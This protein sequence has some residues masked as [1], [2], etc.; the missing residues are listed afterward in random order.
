MIW[1]DAST[2]EVLMMTAGK[3]SKKTYQQITKPIVIDDL[4]GLVKSITLDPAAP[5]SPKSTW[6]E[7][8]RLMAISDLEGNYRNARKFLETNKLIDQKSVLQLPRCASENRK[9]IFFSRIVFQIIKLHQIKTLVLQCL[10][11]ARAT[12]ATGTGTE[13]EFPVAATDGKGTINGVMNGKG[14]QRLFDGLAQKNGKI[15]KGVFGS[16][17]R[18]GFNLAENIS[19]SGKQIRGT[20][21]LA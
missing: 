5:S 13:D 18:N 9:I 17:G 2:A 19:E 15:R 14:A 4:P 21:G 7:P 1:K 12:P 8:S 3:V 6:I 11:R 20:D 16:A 10:G